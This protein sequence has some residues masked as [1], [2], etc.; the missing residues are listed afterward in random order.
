VLFID[1]GAAF[2]S[3]SVASYTTQNGKPKV[4]IQAV[5]W[6]ETLGGAQFDLRLANYL[7]DEFDKQTGFKI[8]DNLKA[9]T[10]LLIA[11][12]KAKMQLSANDMTI[13]SIGSLM[14]DKDFKLKVE[15]KQL[16]ELCADLY[17]KIAAPVKKVLAET[18]LEVSALS[19]VVPFG[20]GWR[21]PGLQTALQ[22]ELGI[23]KLDTILNSDEAAAFGS[24]F[25]HGNNSGLLRVKE[26]VLEDTTKPPKAAAASSPLRGAAM[27]NAKNKHSAMCDAEEHRKK[28]EGA[29]S[30]LEAWIY[31]VKE[32]G[33]EDE[34]EQ[35]AS[36]DDVSEM[37]AAL[38]AGEDWIYE[39]GET[40]EVAAI[41]AKRAEIEGKVAAIVQRFEEL[42]ARP[43]AVETLRSR[44]T[45]AL[46]NAKSWAESR[47][48]IGAEKLGELSKMATAAQKLLDDGMAKL[49]GDGLKGPLPFT[50]SDLLK[51]AQEIKDLEG[52]LLLIRPKEKE[53]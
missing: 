15:R 42:T 21:V 48:Q 25:I 19:H 16:D 20:G 40:A 41:E 18:K 50:S 46:D 47:P 29:K 53:L 28:R 39:D 2:T 35:V 17:T 37:N 23:A 12:A 8:R 24:V 30:S 52:V 49:T 3:A 26:I 4:T 10:K 6:D 11:A 34:M 13:V 22:E 43:P 38:S 51:K 9:F 33:M 32:K 14:N 36:E 7:A 45:R 27:G 44:I 31:S 1:V 5:A